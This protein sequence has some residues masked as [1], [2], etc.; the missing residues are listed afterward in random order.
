MVTDRS[1]FGV[2]FS[3]LCKGEVCL[4]KDLVVA[5]LE[6]KERILLAQTLHVQASNTARLIGSESCLLPCSHG[7]LKA[8]TG[9]VPQFANHPICKSIRIMRPGLAHTLVSVS[10]EG[11]TFITTPDHLIVT[12]ILDAQHARVL[13]IHCMDIQCFLVVRCTVI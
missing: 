13:V 5:C 11:Q 10:G 9:H 2:S 1:E 3:G 8:G 6:R 4:Y 7:H 12:N